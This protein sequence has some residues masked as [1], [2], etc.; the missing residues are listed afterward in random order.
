MRKDKK[1]IVH[2]PVLHCHNPLQLLTN[3]WRT[4]WG[5]LCFVLTAL[6]ETEQDPVG[7][8]ALEAFPCPLFFVR[9][10][11]QPQWA[12]LSS[13]GQTQTVVNL[14]RRECRDKGGTAK[15]QQFSLGSGAGSASRN[16]HNNMFMLFIEIKTPT[17]ERCMHGWLHV[18][19]RPKKKKICMYTGSSSTTSKFWASLSPEMRCMISTKDCVFKSQNEL[20]NLATTCL[21][22]PLPILSLSIL[23]PNYLS[24]TGGKGSG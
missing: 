24:E 19:P 16:T 20:Y 23:Y 11:L 9:N 22:P 14:G 7:L 12:S 1:S 17:D 10:R 5:S 4:E 2:H 13:K 8:L 21:S 18:F 3:R 6:C 15:S